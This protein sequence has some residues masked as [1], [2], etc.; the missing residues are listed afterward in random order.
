VDLPGDTSEQLMLRTVKDDLRAWN[1]NRVIWVVDRGFTSAADRRYLQRGGG[2]YIMGEKLR[3]DSTE[4][5]TALGR[6]G[7]YRRVA[8]NL[9]VKEVRIDDGTNRDRFVICHNPERAT[10]DAE[11]RAQILTRL[12]TKIAGSD[13]LPARKRAELAGALKT[14]PAFNRFLRTTPGGKLR[15]DHTAVSRETHFD[16]KFLLRTSDESLTAA[17]IAEGY[18]ALY[19]AERG[20]R[21]LKSTIDIRPVYHHKDQRIQAH[22]QLCW[23]ALLLLRVA[24][25]AC[26]DTWRNLRD[27]LE[28]LHLVV[29]RTAEGTIAQRSELTA[30][31]QEILRRLQLPEP[32][33]FYQ[34]TPAHSPPA[35]SPPRQDRP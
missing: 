29:L 18:K 15:I 28:R 2:H 27:E 20:F 10:R 23:L 34:F 32:P 30:R 12:E 35:T 16:G 5:S 17:D 8:G 3:S 21:D 11:V 22:V 1:V 13:Q 33:R 25:L 24:E 4:A 9:R 31:H 14:R 26:R 6:A 19:E 7:R